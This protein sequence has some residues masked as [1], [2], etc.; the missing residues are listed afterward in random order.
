MSTA[1]NWQVASARA[2]QAR[3]TTTRRRLSFR[4]R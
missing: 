4:R 1:I 3:R 2:I